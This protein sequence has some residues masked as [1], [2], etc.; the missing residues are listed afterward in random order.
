[1]TIIREYKHRAH[2]DRGKT[3]EAAREPGETRA[4]T[5]GTPIALRSDTVCALL[6]PSADV[7]W[8]C[9][10]TADVDATANGVPLPAN[11]YHWIVVQPHSGMVVEV[12]AA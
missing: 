1:M 2:G 6:V 12:V 9:N 5:L 8:D 3:I 10:V 7:K 4:V 11:A